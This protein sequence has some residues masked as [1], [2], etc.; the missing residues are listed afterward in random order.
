MKLSNCMWTADD[1][2]IITSSWLKRVEKKKTTFDVDIK[3][4]NADTGVIEYILNT[5]EKQ[6]ITGPVTCYH[7]FHNRYPILLFILNILI[8]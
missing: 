3:C 2:A 1:S 4:W 6:A 5:G 7:C 8:F